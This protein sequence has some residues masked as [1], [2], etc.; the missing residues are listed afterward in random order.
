V[1]GGPLLSTL[2]EHLCWRGDLWVG[3]LLQKKL[4]GVL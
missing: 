1:S 2:L 3:S 4:S